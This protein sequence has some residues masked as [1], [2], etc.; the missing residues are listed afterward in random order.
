MSYIVIPLITYNNTFSRPYYTAEI[1]SNGQNFI[2]F[3]KATGFLI[4]ILHS[5][6]T[7]ITSIQSRFN[8]LATFIPLKLSDPTTLTEQNLDDSGNLRYGVEFTACQKLYLPENGKIQDL[9]LNIDNIG[10]ANKII[11]EIETKI[12]I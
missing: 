9:L 5:T 8:N 3:D 7:V 4:N 2:T 12:A 6:D 10:S 11:L 1:T